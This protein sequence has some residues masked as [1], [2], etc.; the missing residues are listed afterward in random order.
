MTPTPACGRPR[1]EGAP[2][3]AAAHL[4]AWSPDVPFRPAPASPVVPDRTITAPAPRSG[5]GGMLV[6]LAKGR[7]V[8][9][10]LARDTR[11]G[12]ADGPVRAVRSARVARVGVD[13]ALGDGPG[14]ARRGEALPGIFGR[15]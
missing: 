14:R 4:A 10:G 13:R 12:G 9:A 1:A 3:A 8:P 11:M 6:A 15:G 5:D 7:A 2:V